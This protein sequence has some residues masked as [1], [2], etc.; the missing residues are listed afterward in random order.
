M[1]IRK[2]F[3]PSNNNNNL[4]NKPVPI[5][6]ISTLDTIQAEPNEPT[7]STDTKKEE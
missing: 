3:G 7:T 5:I 4:D 1:N 6:N 2:I